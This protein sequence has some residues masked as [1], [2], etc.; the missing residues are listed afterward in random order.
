[1]YLNKN[2]LTS[3]KFIKNNYKKKKKNKIELTYRIKKNKKLKKID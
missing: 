2:A 1:M 3:K